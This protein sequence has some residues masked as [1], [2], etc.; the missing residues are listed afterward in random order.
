MV[1]PAE[2]IARAYVSDLYVFPSSVSP[3]AAAN[4]PFDELID[5]LGGSRSI[6]SA[7]PTKFEAGSKGV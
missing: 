1:D 3:S 6:R 5:G 7:P 4:V 2:F